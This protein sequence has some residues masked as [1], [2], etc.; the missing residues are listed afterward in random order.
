MS[1]VSQPTQPSAP[2]LGLTIGFFKHFVD[3]HGGRDAFQGLSTT[4]VCLRFVK[5]YTKASVMSLVDHVKRYNP[6]QN[7]FVKEA[8]W[9]VSHAWEYKY[10]DVVDALSDFFDDQG[11]ESNDIAVWFCMFNNNQHL[12]ND[13]VIPFQFWV[14]SFETSLTAIGN[15]VMVLSPWNNPA[16]LTRTWCVFEIYVVKKTNARFQVAMGKTQK[17]EFLQSTR[18]KPDCFDKMLGMIKSENSTTA[19][20]TD[21][22]NILALMQADKITWADLDRMTFDVL[23]EWMFR[24]LQ[25]L[26]DGSVSAEKAKW[27]YVKACCFSNNGFVEEARVCL[28]DALYIYRQ[29]LNDEHVDTWKTLALEASLSPCQS[30]DVWEPI[31]QEALR[32]QIELLGTDHNDTLL[33]MIELGGSYMGLGMTAKALP[34]LQETFAKCEQ[35][36]GEFDELTLVSMNFIG[37]CFYR[38]NN[39][40]KAEQ[41]LDDCHDRW[42]RCGS[43]DSPYAQL[44]SNLLAGIY[45]KQGKMVLAKNMFQEIYQSRRRTLGPNH[46]FTWASLKE[47]GL[48]SF[49]MGQMDEAK[50]ILVEC[51]DASIRLNHS[52]CVHLDC[53]QTLG[54][55]STWTGDP[56]QAFDY[57]MEAVKGFRELLSPTNKTTQTA[58]LFLS[59][60]F[61]ETMHQQSLFRLAAFEDELKQAN[62]YRDTWVGVCCK[63]CLE[64][65]QGFLYTCVQCPIYVL[66]F[67]HRCVA[68]TKHTT[69]C[70]HV[71]RL[72]SSKPPA[73]HLQERRLELLAQGANW[74]EYDTCFQDYQEFC[75]VHEVPQD[76]RVK[77]VSTSRFIHF[78]QLM[79]V[80]SVIGIAFIHRYRFVQR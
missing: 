78:I 26:I 65:I 4:D 2:V 14:D 13:A 41:I 31:F 62:E 27:Y 69:F 71:G 46:D 38:D 70:D 1:E 47:V 76:E 49:V 32:H 53:L 10:L 5:P 66:K 80:C 39:L 68:L 48:L 56:D 74:T 54:L 44:V 50:G 30:I 15:V 77:R 51:L 55:L 9:F 42:H 60:Y 28:K 52:R 45:A 21:R 6:K 64:P 67:C 16:T 22:D 57:L 43:Q 25:T 72:K 11:L 36:V 61:N 73:R 59:Y 34:L 75:T 35:L 19:V 29:E 18:Y 23:Q 20:P 33:T 79:G 63:I 17:E 24:T 8:K 40:H 3:L 37:E 7:E 12:V 58:L